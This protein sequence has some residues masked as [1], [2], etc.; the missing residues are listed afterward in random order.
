MIND[1]AVF[2]QRFRCPVLDAFFYY[3]TLLGT[4]WFFIAV[5]PVLY[6][7][8]N[9]RA[10]YRLALVFLF[11]DWTK[12]ALKATFHTPRPQPSP[13]AEV[14]HP[15]TGPG[16]S[17]PSGHAESSTVFW[18]QLALEVKRKWVWFAAAVLTVLVSLSRIYM[19]L[20]W[21]I[22]ILG[23]FVLGVVLLV[24]Y[25]AACALW[26]NLRLPFGV[27]LACALIFP[28]AMY[29]LYREHDALIVIG[30]MLGFPV[31]RLLEERYLGWDERASFPANVFKVVL[32]LGVLFG[33]RFGLKMVFPDT[34]AADIARYAIAGFWA[35]FGAPLLFA[36]FGWQR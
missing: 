17:F 16:Y 23:G 28:A 33:I 3:M 19:N 26:A 32:G 24:L 10:G 34:A 27:R 20:H 2:L 29:L 5:L 1:W 12:N 13:G 9:K 15:E 11:G 21:P 30:F 8:W 18:G 4:G 6:W 31:G 7:T 25:N 22:D 36:A 14:L 35:S